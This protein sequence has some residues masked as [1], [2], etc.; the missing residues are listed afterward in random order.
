MEQLM[1]KL[2]IMRKGFLDFFDVKSDVYFVL[3]QLNVPVTN[4]LHMKKSLIIIFIP[5]NLR[6]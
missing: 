3:N 6:N 5:V 1:Q 2:G 4:L